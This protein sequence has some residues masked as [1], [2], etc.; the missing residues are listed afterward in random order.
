MAENYIIDPSVFYWI[1]ALGAI[2]VLACI[3]GSILLLGSTV[4]F[5]A[6]LYNKTESISYKMEYHGKEDTSNA[7][8]LYAKMS[9]KV[10]ILTFI[11]GAIILIV[12]IFAPDK[13]TSVEML[14]ARTATF[15][16]VNW[17]IEQIK[18]IID[19]IINT[20]KSI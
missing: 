17:T 11:F 16:N 14:V 13:S 8:K 19:Y 6:Y 5:I 9:A 3:I 18:E 12:G 15:D 20:I 10:A 1:S 4:A 2:K 7:Y